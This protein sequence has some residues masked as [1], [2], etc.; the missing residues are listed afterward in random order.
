MALALFDFDGTLTTKDT[1]RGFIYFSCGPLRTTIGSVVLAPLVLGY[2]RGVVSG[3]VLRR[4]A[5]GFC[6]RGR[7]EEDIAGCGRRYARNF[8][9]WLRPEAMSRLR[10]HQQQGDRVAVVS[11]SLSAYLR[12]WT[13]SIG[14][15][16]LCTELEARGGVHT[17]RFAGG[18]CSGEEKA[19]RVRARY[20]LGEFERIYAYGDTTEDHA[21]LRLAHR[22]YFCGRE[23]DPAVPVESLVP[24]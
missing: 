10:W 4:A 22:R 5:A 6:F 7:S 24:A 3:A 19:R 8:D 17:G 12:P 18:D 23:V 15:E 21:L 1:F 11:A 2:Q 16:L 14:V 20:A 13:E 9:A